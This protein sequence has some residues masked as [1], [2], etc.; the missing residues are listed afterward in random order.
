MQRCLCARISAVLR[1]DRSCTGLGTSPPV[2]Q[3]C[4]PCSVLTTDAGSGTTTRPLDDTVP[5][6]QTC[7]GISTLMRRLCCT[8]MLCLV[9]AAVSACCAV[10]CG[11]GLPFGA[12]VAVA[13]EPGA[14]CSA[15]ACSVCAAQ[16]GTCS[17]CKRQHNL[18]WGRCCQQHGPAMMAALLPSTVSSPVL[19]AEAYE[20][21]QK[22]GGRCVVWWKPCAAVLCVALW[23]SCGPSALLGKRGKRWT[24]AS[25]GRPPPSTAGVSRRG[26]PRWRKQTCRAP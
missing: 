11:T 23:L 24:S 14:E 16:C 17:H 15:E 12:F 2:T 20:D 3:I 18:V 5:L 9:A 22:R 6:N 4:E 13:Q 1:L 19:I 21:A 10:D 7:F 26:D 8:W 25:Q